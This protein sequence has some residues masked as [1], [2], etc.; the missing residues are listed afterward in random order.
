MSNQIYIA[1]CSRKVSRS[2]KNLLKCINENIINDN[3]TCRVVIILNQIKKIKN[4][5][6]LELKKIIKKKKLYI[7]YEKK[8]GVSYV[9][10]RAINFLKKKNFDYGC[11]IDDDCKVDKN[12]LSSH[13]NFI[14]KNKCSIVGGPQ[15][16]LS[17]PIYFRTFERSFS[18]NKKLKWVSTNNVFFKKK[19]LNNNIMFSQKVT[20]YGYGEDQLFFTQMSIKG[21]KILWNN[22]PVYEIRQKKR[23]NLSWFFDRNLKYGLTGY[24]IDKI[25]YGKYLSVIIN[26][27]KICYY[28]LYAVFNLFFIMTNLQKKFYLVLSSILKAVGRFISLKNFND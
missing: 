16:Y 22:N 4:N 27:M 11:F 14:K 1:I 18:T 26:F 17:K 9:R 8:I 25:I 7:I 19:I 10:N 28:L 3:L 20:K 21:E 5:Q 23:E 6:N 13:L 2:L 24:L 12:Y 15:L